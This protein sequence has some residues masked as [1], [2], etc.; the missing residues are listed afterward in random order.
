[1]SSAVYHGT[2]VHAR[3]RPRE[4]V[5]RYRVCFYLLDLDELDELD[6]RVRLFGN[7]RRQLVSLRA[8]DHLGE[9]ERTLRENVETCLRQEGIEPPGGRIEL[10]TN[11]RVAGYLFNPISFFYV[12]DAREQLA[13]VVAEVHN[14]FG[15]RWPYVLSPGEKGSSAET[16]PTQHALEAETPKRLHVS[17][18][19]GMDQRYAFA[20]SCPESMVY[21]RV[22]V[23]EAGE[24]VFASVLSGEREP[25]TSASLR[26]SLLR[27]PLMPARVAVGIHWNALQLRLKGVPFHPKPPPPAGSERAA[28]AIPRPRLRRG[29]TTP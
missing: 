1:M 21:A 4:H 2:L 7:E 20:L 22:D 14:T 27:Y 5:F 11:L 12:Y 8:S 29:S 16:A 23:S 10:L 26:K 19:F 15:E 6:A 3:R 25:L 28:H 24:R 18:F 9:A 17:P 13:H